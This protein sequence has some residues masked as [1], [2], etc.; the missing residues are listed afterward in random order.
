MRGELLTNRHLS[1]GIL[2]RICQL[3]SNS[4]NKGITKSIKQFRKLA[5]NKASNFHL[6]PNSGHLFTF[7]IYLLSGRKLFCLIV[8]ER[9]DLET[10][11]Y[12]AKKV[13]FVRI[14]RSG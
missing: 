7:L 14:I 8:L 3:K 2:I 1:D 4:S 9:M 11:R 12:L 5:R 10:P 13:D 6:P